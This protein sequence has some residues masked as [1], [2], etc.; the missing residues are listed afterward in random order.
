MLPVY[1]ISKIVSNMCVSLAK[2][3]CTIVVIN[4]VNCGGLKGETLAYS[5]SESST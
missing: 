1:P 4:T 2:H 3:S 5:L